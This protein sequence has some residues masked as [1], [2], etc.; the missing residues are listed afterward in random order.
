MALSAEVQELKDAL[1]AAAQR[2]VAEATT[3]NAKIAALQAALDAGTMSAEDKAALVAL[4]PVAKG[5]D[6]NDPSTLPPA[7]AAQPTPV[8][9]GAEQ[10]K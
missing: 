6:P 5:I 7:P 4:I 9:G 2:S 3:N 1:E 8:A 10:A